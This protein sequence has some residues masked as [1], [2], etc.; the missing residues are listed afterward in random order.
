MNSK[1]M[2]RWD[3]IWGNS[4]FRKLY[5]R[6]KVDLQRDFLYVETCETVCRRATSAD[7]AVAQFAARSY[8]KPVPYG[9]TLI[10]VPGI[11]PLC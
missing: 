11:I 8:T 1:F 5:V 2:T 9:V 4:K 7:A 6:G 3:R 10:M